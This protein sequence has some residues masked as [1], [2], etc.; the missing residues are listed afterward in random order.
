MNAPSAPFIVHPSSFIVLYTPLMN[1]LSTRL[2][3]AASD[4][5]SLLGDETGTIQFD[6][7]YREEATVAG[8]RVGFIRLAIDLLKA[9]AAAEG[10]PLPAP[11][12]DLLDSPIEE[13]RRIDTPADATAAKTSWKDRFFATGCLLFAVIA[14]IA[15]FRGC[16]AL[17]HDITR[18]LK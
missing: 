8:D 3:A 9:A 17:Q 7:D 4:L 14:V 16:V 2:T 18:F 10:D 11:N 5:E 12:P 6:G 1:D 15:F 13:Y